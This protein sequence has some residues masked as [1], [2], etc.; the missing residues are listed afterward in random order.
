MAPTFPETAWGSALRREQRQ[1]GRRCDNSTDGAVRTSRRLFTANNDQ[2][3]NALQRK[4]FSLEGVVNHK[5][6]HN[7]TGTGI[8]RCFI[9][10]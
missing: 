8:D 5:T 4:G 9:D 3:L 2:T 1:T 6:H 10:E 7:S